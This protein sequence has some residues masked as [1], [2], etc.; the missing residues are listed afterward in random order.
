MEGRTGNSVGG[1]WKRRLFYGLCGLIFLFLVFPI[2]IFSLVIHEVSHGWAAY[3]MGDRTAMWLGRLTLNPLRHLDPFG[4][5]ALLFF[6]FGWAKP[7]PVNYL[8][9][10]DFRKGIF[11]VSIAGVAANFLFAFIAV[12][13]NRLTVSYNIELLYSALSIIAYIN[14]LLA[15]FNIIPIP[16]LDGSKVL[17]SFLPNEYRYYMER[18][19]PYGMFII[20]ALLFMGILNPVIR[21]FQSL[22]IGIINI[23]L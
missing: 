22:I 15:A 21:F 1:V 10:R 20:L 13:V 4:T 18:I 19:E 16:P 9:L 6:G 11:L 5:I 12:L 23:F 17:I 3:L 8:N 7:V 2:L 14:I